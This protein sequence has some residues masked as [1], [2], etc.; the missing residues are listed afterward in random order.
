MPT[1]RSSAIMP[2]L[3]D[4]SVLRKIEEEMRTPAKE[5]RGY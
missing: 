5:K 4:L 2:T 3:L 1:T